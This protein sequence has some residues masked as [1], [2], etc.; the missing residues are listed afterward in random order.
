M[1]LRSLALTAFIALLSLSS[2]AGGFDGPF[3]QAG[4]G[5]SHGKSRIEFPGWF[6]AST[7]GNRQSGQIS[8]GYS[9]SF[10]HFNLAASAYYLTGKQTTGSTTQRYQNTAEIDEIRQ[11]LKNSWGIR[12]EPGFNLSESTLFYLSLGYGKTKG[13]WRFSRPLF[14]DQFAGNQTFR[15]SSLG[16]GM[17]HKFAANLY[18]FVEIQQVRY[19][20]E[21]IIMT[22]DGNP[23][24]DSFKPQTS[25]IFLGAGYTF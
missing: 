21:T 6:T 1:P 16:V 23:Y 4:I 15:G 2:R 19:R 17:K 10:G 11:E 25:S 22:V 13:E 20:K 8:G 7:S 9:H 18:G 12:I 5:I 14:R 3:I 24:A